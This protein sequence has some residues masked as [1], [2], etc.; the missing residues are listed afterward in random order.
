MAASVTRAAI[1]AGALLY[2]DLRPG[3]TD[4]HVDTE[5][6][7]ELINLQAAEFWDKLVQARGADYY[8]TPATVQ[9]VA[10]TATVALPS[11]F[12]ELLSVDLA[13]GSDRIEP[14]QRLSNIADRWI[15]RRVLWAEG[16]AKAFRESGTGTGT[17]L[18]F[19][20]TPNAQTTVELRYVPSFEP[21]AT[22]DSD[23]AATID[24]INGWHKLVMLG[25][26]VELRM[27]HGLDPREQREQLAIVM[28]R[29]DELA[30]ERAPSHAQQIRDVHPEGWH[31]DKD[32]KHLLTPP[33]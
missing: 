22:D 33:E 30:S 25:T 12:Y 21:W 9:T 23:D 28:R 16:S 27:I 15:Y 32:W 31:G 11:A 18:E 13:W 26:A 24:G 2:A 19:F 17:V 6:V 3:G 20:P 5:E 29:M 10:G 14:V 1:R 8:A 4:E 7:N